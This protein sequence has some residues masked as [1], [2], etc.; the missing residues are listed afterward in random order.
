M[1]K[2]ALMMALAATCVAAAAQKPGQP[3]WLS[4]AVFY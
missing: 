2:I 1:R 4:E 3:S